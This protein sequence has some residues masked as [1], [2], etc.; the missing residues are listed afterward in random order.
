MTGSA[1]ARL[2]LSDLRVIATLLAPL[3]MIGA[4]IASLRE[5]RQPEPA[6]RRNAFKGVVDEFLRSVS[7]GSSTA[8]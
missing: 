2:S 5:A 7:S 4:P 3:A 1:G 8:T 6:F